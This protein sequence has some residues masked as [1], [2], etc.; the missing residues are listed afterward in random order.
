M[1]LEP[2][3]LLI[4]GGSGLADCKRRGWPSAFRILFETQSFIFEEE[5]GFDIHFFT[6]DGSSCQD[7]PPL[8]VHPQE[9]TSFGQRLENAIECLAQKGYEE[10]V[11]VGRDCPDL[12]QHDILQAEITR[13]DTGFA[14]EHIEAG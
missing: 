13:I 10:I 6:T 3:A 4:F 9:G 8:H 5:P 1:P 7:E 2:R 14:F 12:E 11:I